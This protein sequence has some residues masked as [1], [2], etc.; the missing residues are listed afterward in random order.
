MAPRTQGEAMWRRFKA[1]QDAVFARTSV[2]M[3]AQHDARLANQQ[4][5]QALCERAEALAMSSEWVKTAAEMQALQAEWKTVGQAARG[6]EK[7]LWERFRVAC[8]GFFSRRQEDLRKR[9][10]EWSQNLAQKEALC[11]EAERLSQS[12]EWEASAAQL[13][14]LQAQW[15]AI[16]P[17]RRT[18]SEALWQRFRSA[19]DGFFERY[20]HKDQLALQEK[21]AARSTVVRDLEALAPA[22]GAA[23]APVPDELY[24]HVQ[25]ARTAWQH[26]PEVPRA[27]QQDLAVQYHDVLGRIVSRWP[28]AFAGTDL[29]PEATRK[30]MEKLLARVEQLSATQPGMPQ[31]L[32]PA[33]LLAMRLR[34]RLAT[35]TISGGQAK[36]GD[37]SKDREAEQEVRNAQQQWMRLGPVPASV[38]GPLN[39]RFQRAC[40]KFFEDRRRAS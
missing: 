24:D 22:D 1:A 12:T 4:K 8:D 6:H 16:G 26:A 10:D 9:K 34:E 5:K 25:R 32:S 7:A 23:D 29:D 13:K 3:A 40:R 19:C 18:K 31:S 30:R 38:A 33:E 39:E 37:E 36:P 15:K 28:G 2:F 20:K 14:R 11:E 21:A 27:L 17:V 35:N